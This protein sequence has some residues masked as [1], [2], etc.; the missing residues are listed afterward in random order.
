M[1]CKWCRETIII[2]AHQV[3][4]FFLLLLSPRMRKVITVSYTPTEGCD[5]VLDLT[6]D[7]ETI[8]KMCGKPKK[9]KRHTTKFASQGR[10]KFIFF[11]F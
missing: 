11:F 10:S 7:K 9:K 5:N 3:G 8:E 1:K 2:G 4:P 6:A